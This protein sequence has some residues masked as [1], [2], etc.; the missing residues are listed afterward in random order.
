MT[1]GGVTAKGFLSELMKSSKI[2]SG[3]GGTIL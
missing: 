2:D 3:D 1:W